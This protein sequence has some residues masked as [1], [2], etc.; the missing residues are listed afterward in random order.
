MPSDIS[1][2][3]FHVRVSGLHGD[4][5]RPVQSQPQIAIAPGTPRTPGARR[6]LNVQLHL[7]AWIFKKQRRGFYE[8]RLD[9]C[10]RAHECISRRMQEQQAGCVR[11]KE[12]ID[13]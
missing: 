8:K 2:V 13:E 5:A 10:E 4:A 3:V 1:A 6:T 11:R 7:H 12:R 9:W